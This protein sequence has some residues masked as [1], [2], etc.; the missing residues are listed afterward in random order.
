MV[1]HT[2]HDPI[3][4]R[5]RSHLASRSRTA[6][7]PMTRALALAATTAL[8]ATGVLGVTSQAPAF[9]DSGITTTGDVNL[10]TG[11]GTQY[12][13]LDVVPTGSS[14]IYKCW[15]P[16][17]EINR[18]DV[19]FQVSWGDNV[20]YIS[21]YFD[22]SSYANDSDITGR[23][24]IPPCSQSP[25]VGVADPGVATDGSA[26]PYDR[27]A[28]VSWALSNATS[29]QDFPAACTWFVSQALWAGGLTRDSEWTSEGGH[30]FLWSARPGTAAATAV[31]PFIDYIL[32]RFP[33]SSVE[34][35]DLAHNPVPLA[36]PGD[37]M[38]YDWEG[39][40]LFDHVS[41]VT[42]ISPGEYPNV[43]EW[44]TVDFK[45]GHPSSFYAER[46][47]TWSEKN[48]EWLQRE[49]PNVTAM[50]IHLDTSIPSTY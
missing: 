37:V 5:D 1:R 2:R 39:D 28:A 10:R 43:S 18:V 3:A 46:G 21:S 41:V 17:E 27:N 6:R 35:L 50:L 22:D 14:P 48:H 15:A 45:F 31:R 16:G 13:I 9:A 40:G 11:P 30:G 29:P 24:G 32:N 19:W 25:G 34:Y 12:G 26:E 49:Y 42:S 36:Q 20:G 8:T 44:G 38:A 23:Y 7:R 47:W 4:A 33:N